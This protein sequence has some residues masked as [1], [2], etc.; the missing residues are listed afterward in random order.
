MI[1]IT[2]E[3]LDRLEKRFNLEVSYLK[4]IRWVIFQD[5]LFFTN[6]KIL[7]FLPLKENISLPKDGWNESIKAHIEKICD[8]NTEYFEIPENE[9]C[10]ICNGTG[11]VF[12]KECPECEGRGFITLLYEGIYDDYE[13]EHTCKYCSGKGKIKGDK[14]LIC[15]ECEG[16]GKKNK[17]II[18]NE[19]EVYQ[20]YFDLCKIKEI[21]YNKLFVNENILQFEFDTSNGKAYGKVVINLK[22]K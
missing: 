7:I 21:R 2:K 14:G 19:K 22:N 10:D 3:Y 11:F 13:Y 18:I 8:D 9:N 5:W 6:G 17:E 20:L 1:K 15:E 4:N 16:S 12:V